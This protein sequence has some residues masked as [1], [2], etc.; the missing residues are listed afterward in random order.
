MKPDSTTS[1]SAIPIPGLYSPGTIGSRIDL[2]IKTRL[3]NP[4]QCI[5]LSSK[6]PQHFRHENSER[7]LGAGQNMWNAIIYSGANVL[8][9]VLK[10]ILYF[11]AVVLDLVKPLVGTR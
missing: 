11:I 3:A 1:V 6:R 5:I 10:I 8:I 7:L 9:E 4:D 2:A